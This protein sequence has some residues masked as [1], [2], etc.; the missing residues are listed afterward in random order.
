[1]T[2]IGIGD[3]AEI[4]DVRA[5]ELRGAH[6]D[7]RHVGRQVVPALL[8][9]NE[10]R[11]RLLV[12]QM[13]AFVARVEVRVRR[14]VHGAAADAFEEIERVGDRAGDALIAVLERRVMDEAEIPVLRDGAGRRSRRRPARARNSA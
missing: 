2:A 9:R 5:V 7:P 4:F 8:A 14:L 6:A 10:A 1:M 13:Q 11:L 12:Q 3:A